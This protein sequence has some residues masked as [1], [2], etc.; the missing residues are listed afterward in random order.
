LEIYDPTY[1]VAFDLAGDS[2]AVVAGANGCAVDIVRP[3]APDATQQADA[4]K[5][6]QADFNAMMGDNFGAQFV[7]RILVNCP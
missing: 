4:L 2:P 1:Y 3:K 7:N 6:D 5:L